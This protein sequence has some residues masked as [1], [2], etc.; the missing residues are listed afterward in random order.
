MRQSEPDFAVLEYITITKDSRTG[1][2]IALGGTQEAAGILQR[3]GFLHAP[4][5]RGEYHRLPTAS[6]SETSAARPR[7]P[8]TPC[9]PPVT[10]SISPRR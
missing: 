3:N 2:V 5:P 6:R 1:L 9:S 8:R 10:A 4:G 7:P